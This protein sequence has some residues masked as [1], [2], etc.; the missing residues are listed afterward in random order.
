[1][2]ILPVTNVENDVRPS[3]R[4]D[5]NAVGNFGTPSATRCDVKC[6]LSLFGP[7]C[8]YVSFFLLLSV[9]QVQVILQIKLIP[10]LG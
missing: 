2:V 9:V 10:R 7:H 6:R 5:D 1:M 8:S 3:L 4:N